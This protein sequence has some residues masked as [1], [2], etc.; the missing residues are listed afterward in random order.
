MAEVPPVSNDFAL[1]RTPW[2]LVTRL[3]RHL[4][5]GRHPVTA[6]RSAVDIELELGVDSQPSVHWIGQAA[7]GCAVEEGTTTIPVVKVTSVPF[8]GLTRA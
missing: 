5:E 2:H 8:D 6:P 3:L 1:P 4:P 7:S